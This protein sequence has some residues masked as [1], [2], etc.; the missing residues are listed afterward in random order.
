MGRSPGLGFA[1]DYAGAESYISV[2]HARLGKLT[3][4][5]LKRQAKKPY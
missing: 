2:M 3:E 4:R 5:V 1:P